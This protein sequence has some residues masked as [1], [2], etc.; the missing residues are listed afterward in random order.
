MST[1][2]VVALA[3]ADEAV[4]TEPLTVALVNDYEVVV[5]GLGSMLAGY[6]DRLLIVERDVRLPVAQPVDVAL[7]DTF[8]QTH[9]PRSEVRDIVEAAAARRVVVYSWNL[10]PE[11]IRSAL[12]LGVDG[13]LSKALSSA[14]LVDALVRVC[15]GE[16]VVSAPVAD[17]RTEVE[18]S[19]G[20]WPGRAEG[21]TCR[22]SEILA[23]ITRGLSN[24]DIA[25]RTHLSINTVKSYIR[26]AYRR[27][28]VTTRSQ[29]V[30]WGVR[31][32]FA[33]EPPRRDRVVG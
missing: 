27:M 11:V 10:Q 23:L 15:A 6:A 20:D 12:D 25:D 26:S 33:L 8:S 7:F 4:S 1:D 21:L 3:S 16:R 14:Q 19:G 31:H 18:V 24:A 2:D 9:G 32:G 17:E 5:R 13:Y 28:G 30:G 29:A 22:E